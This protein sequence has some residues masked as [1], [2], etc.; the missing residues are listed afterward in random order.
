L[1][2]KDFLPIYLG[3]VGKSS[4]LLRR[5]NQHET[6][7]LWNRWENFSWFG[8]RRVNQTGKLSLFDNVNKVFRVPG[9]KLL[10]QIEGALLTTLEPKL[11]KQGAR[12]ID[13]VEEYFQ[14][15]DDEK[16]DVE[17]VDVLEGHARIEKLITGL[18]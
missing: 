11:N 9:F 3:Q 12:W 1:Y 5:L 18:G 13:D 2:D 6:D 14:L 7:H 4:G 17:L 8:L 15:V 16:R 10:N